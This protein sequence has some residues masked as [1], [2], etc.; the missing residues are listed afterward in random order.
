[1]VVDIGVLG[2]VHCPFSTLS[3]RRSMILEDIGG[4]DWKIRRY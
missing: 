1:V 2:D 4:R 3:I